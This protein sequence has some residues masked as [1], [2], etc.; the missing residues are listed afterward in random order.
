MLRSPSPHHRPAVPS[1][2]VRGSTRNARPRPCRYPRLLSSSLHAALY[3]RDEHSQMSVST[4]S[5][6]VL[7]NSHIRWQRHE[8]DA[9][10]RQVQDLKTRSSRPC[11]VVN[12][13]RGRARRARPSGA[14]PSRA[15]FLEGVFR[16]HRRCQSGSSELPPVPRKGHQVTCILSGVLGKKRGIYRRW[17]GS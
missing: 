14:S 16:K 17:D 9:P 11:V 5:C 15:P 7:R 3:G 13:P 1:G 8:E 4:F 10:P 2:P 6:P 12:Q